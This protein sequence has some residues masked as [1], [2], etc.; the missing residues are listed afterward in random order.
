MHHQYRIVSKQLDRL[1]KKIAA[2]SEVHGV[3][4]DDEAHDIKVIASIRSHFID[5]LRTDSF[6][7]I[8]WEQQLEAASL[9]DAHSYT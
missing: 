6:R 9:K 2:I 7:H 3:T 4:L 1:K 8:F 5:D